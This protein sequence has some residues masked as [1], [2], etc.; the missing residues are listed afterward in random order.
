[1]GSVSNASEE[2][3]FRL[4]FRLIINRFLCAKN[5]F[6]TNTKETLVGNC[7]KYCENYQLSRNFPLIPLSAAQAWSTARAGQTA[8][9]AWIG[10]FSSNSYNSTNKFPLRTPHNGKFGK[11]FTFYI[12]DA[13]ESPAIHS[14]CG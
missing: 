12:G 8:R 1:M 9:G 6:N 2:P 7:S 11:H 14:H 10:L 3:V 4:L 5:A 13:G